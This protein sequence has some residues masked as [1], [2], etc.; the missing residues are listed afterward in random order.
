[1]GLGEAWP[2]NNPERKI[3]WLW[4][5]SIKISERLNLK[6]NDHTSFKI[7]AMVLLAIIKNKP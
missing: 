5:H 2:V 4:E 7:K 1:M 6:K 3:S